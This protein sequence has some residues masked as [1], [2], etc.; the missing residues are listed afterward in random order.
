MQR[1]NTRQQVSGPR[2]VTYTAYST[3]TVGLLHPHLKPHH[4]SCL[5]MTLHLYLNIDR[6][7]SSKKNDYRSNSE[8]HRQQ[9]ERVILERKRAEDSGIDEGRDINDDDDDA[10]EIAGN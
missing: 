10:V 5:C 2:N 6:N 1:F 9:L 8:K 7:V 3:D 4:T